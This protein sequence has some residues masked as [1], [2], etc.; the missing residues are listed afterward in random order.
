M[1]E[2]I[3]EVVKTELD[4]SENGKTTFSHLKTVLPESRHGRIL[5]ALRI[6]RSQ[7]VLKKYVTKLEDGS[8][9]TVIEKVS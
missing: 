6:G 9:E 4:N 7:G 8:M 2:E 1:L 5:D 3:L